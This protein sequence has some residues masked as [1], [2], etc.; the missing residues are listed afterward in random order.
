MSDWL[1]L[2]PALVALIV[3][4]WKKEVIVA[5]LLSLFCAELLLL[6]QQGESV[7]TATALG[8]LNTLE[9]LIKV[10]SDPG[11][12]RLL[13]FALLVGALMAYMRYSGG[14]NALVSRLVAR[15]IAKNGRQSKLLAFFTGVAIFIESNLSVLT[16]GILSRGLFDKFKIS[17]AELAYII[18]STSAPICILILLNGWGAYVLGLLGSYQLPENPVSI[19]MQTIMLNFYPLFTL[20]LVLF[21]IITGRHY[22]PMKTAWQ[23]QQQ[24]HNAAIDLS[25][26]PE[27]NEGKAR[28]ML[29]P[30]LTMILSMV[31]FMYWTGQGDLAAGSG[32]K[33]VLYATALACLVAYALLRFDNK[34]SHQQLVDIGYKGMSELLALTTILLLAIALGASLKTLGTGTFIAGLVASSMPLFLIPAMMFLAG[35]LISFTTGT[36]WG[37][38]A[39]LI[40]IGM[41]LVL[42]LNLPPAL[43]LAA[44]LGGGIFGDHCS[45]I[46]DTTAVSSVA[47]GCDLLEHVRT[48]M[49]YAVFC[50]V[51]SFI[52][53]LLCGWWMI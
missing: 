15:G 8:G 36:S 13:L 53:Y 39:I 32:S 2:L 33:S 43:V 23:R 16:A 18:D 46:S 48:Q 51:A 30:L 21:T 3:V 47:A 28:Y 14:V 24:L 10:M 50:A 44:I 6:S 20:A 35:A 41:P 12:A 27:I 37:T 4:L 1:T 31:G 19:L 26:G 34:F 22:G 9:A 17:R 29:L 11:N 45:P 40:P 42:E 5:L 38:F 49:P 25:E 52:A 7:V